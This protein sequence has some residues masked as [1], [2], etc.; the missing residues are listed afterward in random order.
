MQVGRV[1]AHIR[2]IV[3]EHEINILYLRGDWF[4]R[5]IADLGVEIFSYDYGIPK[6]FGYHCHTGLPNDTERFMF[7][8][9]DGLV[10]LNEESYDYFQSV[11]GISVPYVLVPSLYFPNHAWYNHPRREKLSGSLGGM[12]CVIPTAV[13][14]LSHI[15]RKRHPLV[16]FNN[17]I[18]DR[19]DYYQ[20]VQQ[21]ARQEIHVYTYGRFREHLK[22]YSEQVESIYRDLEKHSPYIKFMG[23]VSPD[24]FQAEISQYDFT[25]FTGYQ[26]GQVVP[27]FEHMNYQVRFNPALAAQLP[28]MVAQGTGNALE[29]EVREKGVGYVFTS[30]ED[31]KARVSTG[32]FLARTTELC[33]NA[34]NEHSNERWMPELIR[35]FQEVLASPRTTVSGRTPTALPMLR[36]SVRFQYRR[37]WKKLLG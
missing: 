16:P 36:H 24:T 2:Q 22:G 20:L 25:I 27:V 13:I 15:P 33:R 3:V 37:T 8:Q 7:A 1:G 28:I 18:F 14:R 11:Y 32:D 5:T 35:F 21:L 4:D 34:Q 17:Y 23:L 29:R 31:L 19:Y 26:P 12:H 10:L 6:V 9:A 30:F